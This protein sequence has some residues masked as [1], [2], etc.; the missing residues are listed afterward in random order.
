MPDYDPALLHPMTRGDFLLMKR[1]Y[2]ILIILQ[3]NPNMISISKS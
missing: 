2:E 3:Q 1:Q